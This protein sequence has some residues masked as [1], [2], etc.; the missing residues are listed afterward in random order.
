[1]DVQPSA[2]DR[3]LALEARF[4][5]LERKGLALEDSPSLESLR[6][7]QPI[8]PGDEGLLT[9]LLRRSPIALSAYQCNAELSTR[10]IN[11][12]I[13]Q[14]SDQSSPFQFCELSDGDAVLWISAKAPAWAYESSHCLQAFKFLSPNSEGQALTLQRLALFKPIIRGE[15]WTLVQKGELNA[16]ES[17]YP[18]EADHINLSIRIENLERQ[19]LRLSSQQD[20][21]LRELRLQVQTNQEEINRLSS[22]SRK[23]G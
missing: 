1:M 14:Q 21:T 18:E 3:L 8:W 15:K 10:P 17:P 4:E 12:L 2:L 20:V 16:K 6:R 5:Q 11:S 9:R 7:N 22:L 19:L 13:L 23:P